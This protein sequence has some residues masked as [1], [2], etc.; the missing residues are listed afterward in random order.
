[1]SRL[2]LL[3]LVLTVL[4]TVVPMYFILSWLRL[5]GQGIPGLFDAWSA[6]AA[7]TALSWDLVIAGVALSVF[8]VVEAVFR[9]DR[10]CLIAIPATFLIGLSCGWPLYLFLRSRKLP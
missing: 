6:N 3:Y 1:M 7:T 10:L 8:I 5:S 4:G 2:R 9:R